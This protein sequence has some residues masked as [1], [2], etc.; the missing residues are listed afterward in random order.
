MRTLKKI[1]SDI[2]GDLVMA[3][4]ACR[5]L[6]WEVADLAAHGQSQFRNRRTLRELADR[7]QHLYGQLGRD[8]YALLVDGVAVERTPRVD[9][10]LREIRHYETLRHQHARN[11]SHSSE[12]VRASMSSRRLAHIVR[13]GDWQI[14]AVAVAHGSRWVGRDLTGDTPTGICLA[15]RR[16]QSLHPFTSDW[17]FLD[18]DLLMVLA[19]PTYFSDW[20]QWITQG[21]TDVLDT[22]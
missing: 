18:G 8:G 19:P 12:D 2:A 22:R 21:S 15:V 10:T 14:H 6:F 16:D 20:D 11:I 1:S 7:E 4:H 5:D 13:T 17:R 9:A 3:G